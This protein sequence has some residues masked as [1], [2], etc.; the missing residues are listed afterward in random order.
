[1]FGLVVGWVIAW[2]IALQLIWV[3]KTQ[4]GIEASSI[5]PPLPSL[6]VSSQG[7]LEEPQPNA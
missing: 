7:F 3:R 5:V 4:I 6:N 2:G 1:M